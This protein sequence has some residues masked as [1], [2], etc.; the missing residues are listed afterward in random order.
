MSSELITSLLY[1]LL[2]GFWL[3]I[4]FLYLLN[5]R[6]HHGLGGAV[7]VLLV[8]LA[9]DA[10][11]TVFESVYFGSYF[12]SYYGFISPEVYDLLSQP[13]FLIIPKLI[14]LLA[15]CLVLLLL[16]RHW[17]PKQTYER[18]KLIHD[19]AE[20]EKQL[21][22]AIINSPLPTFIHC[23]DGRILMTSQAVHDIT[24][25]QLDEIDTVNKWLKLAYRDRAGEMAGLI[26]REYDGSQK[27]L[28]EFMI[29]TRDDQQRIWSFNISSLGHDR[30]G[31]AL[32]LAVA[33]DIT[34]A[35]Q[36]AD[37][38]DRMLR[39]LDEAQQLAHMGS[40]EH[41][42]LTGEIIWSEETCRILGFDPDN[43]PNDFDGFLQ[44]VYPA[45][46]IGL[47][48]AL[49]ALA[50]NG[51]IE[52]EYR[53]HRASDGQIRWLFDRGKSQLNEVGQEI[54]R[55]GMVADITERKRLEAIKDLEADVL[56]AVTSSLPLTAILKKV[57]L[58]IESLMPEAIASVLLLDSS[59]KTIAESVAP[60]L[61]AAFN[62]AMVG[63]PIGPNAGSCGTAAFLKKTV[64]V[65]DIASDP[66]WE[67][68]RDLALANELLACWSE[69]V[70][71]DAESVIAT[72][73]I[74]H[75]KI[76]TPDPVDLDSIV[77]IARIIT[78]A[79]LRNRSEKRLQ[80]S[81][82]RFRKI[83]E[84]AATGVAVTTPEGHFVHANQAY[85]SML[86]YNEDEL[87]MLN[88][89]TL[90][91]PDDRQQNNQDIQTLLTSGS[92]SRILE[93]RYL[94]KNGDTI[95]AR[96]SVSVQRDEHGK[97]EFL[98]AIAENISEMKLA[99]QRQSEAERSL[100]QL[101]S[102][103]SGFAY[104][105]L[106][107][108]RWTMIYV[109]DAFEKLTGYPPEEV[110]HNQQ[111]DYNS[112]THPED[113]ARVTAEIRYASDNLKNF[114]MEYR[115]VR[116]DGEVRWV[117][118]QG[119]D[120]RDENGNIVAVEG[121]IADIT[122][123]KAIDEVVRQS[124]QR[125]Q[126]LSKAT[127]EV[128]WD[129]DLRTDAI[130]WNEAF[131]TLFG[132]DSDEQE[133]TLAFWKS[134]IHPDDRHR[135]VSD[136]DRAIADKATSW[137]ASYRFIRQDDSIAQVMDRGYLIYD[138]L[139]GQAVRMVGSIT[140]ITERLALE[141]QLRQSQRLE[142]VG[143]LTGG[144]AHD[145][146][147]LL[148]VV[149]G[150]ADIIHQSLPED[151]KLRGLAAMIEEAASRG[152]ALTSSLLAFA[153]R[154]PL[155]P[156]N[157]D[158][159]ALLNKLDTLL[160]RALGEENDCQYMLAE[161]LWLAQ[162]DPALLENALLNLTLN[163]RDAM[164]GNGQLIIETQNIHINEDYAERHAIK[165]G[166]YVQIAVSD[167]GHGIASDQ[168]DK[169]FE[170]FYTTKTKEKGTGLG[171]AMVYG[172]IKQSRG[173]INIYS[174]VGQGT[175][176]RLYLPKAMAATDEPTRIT[177]QE[178]LPAGNETILVVEDD[179]LVRDYV[180][181]QLQFMGYQVHTANDGQSALKL[182]QQ[183]IP[184]D[185]LFTDVVMPNGMSGRELADISL[186]LRPQLR[187]LFTSGYTENSIV[188]HGRLDKG[189]LL[190]S[191]PYNRDELAQKIRQ[192]LSQ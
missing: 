165:T 186:Q 10:F 141:E 6:K 44:Q 22:L 129:W 49:Q 76:S 177:A 69:P 72:F 127:N 45:D 40:W 105:C 135:V 116:K 32:F 89:R 12:T 122:E 88:F 100:S 46:R 191:K 75:R 182:I 43:Y 142:A 137:N 170:P 101:L 30:D 63:E 41:D 66:L 24:G 125:F 187:V 60:N 93:K 138:E 173:H 15:A 120:V 25:Y 31:K 149:I 106:F 179:A 104:R 140:D 176:V 178:K 26:A 50:D 174:E 110:L 67:N 13:Q 17:L 103:L 56:E 28:G 74:Y 181:S 134:R 99:A 157:I 95:W 81:E 4:L 114:Q 113:R 68:Y 118:E 82:Q 14:N 130:W 133:F 112:I 47:V 87:K 158:I 123:Q 148:T 136:L 153:R 117:L 172:F 146:N 65:S 188:H 34:E 53:I 145:F 167:T 71:D 27:F 132:Y 9:I 92:D 192:A 168:L 144:V 59:G 147:N 131:E 48:N 161:D 128:I 169:V 77:R 189:I 185:L 21:R 96:V 57:V 79:I 90:T 42:L 29:H 91:H 111:I 183:G 124:E 36:Q 143:Q 37:E 94:S 5:L 98:V 126:L 39:L 84:Q 150:N 156:K 190:L 51:E 61:P 108:E 175:T 83:F 3:V 97:P 52:T 119:S 73:A 155:D 107:D 11:R 152:A 18:Q 1:W 78:V 2:A 139:K 7:S 154:Q 121:Y 64:V 80:D 164:S 23:E 159:N 162:V 160:A 38:N 20:S 58:G 109:S 115:I 33:N 163:A 8:I 151:S 102:N 16:I 180:V 54:R 35:K 171:L 86:G 62:E 85:C 70:F 184:V 19:V 166:D 55:M